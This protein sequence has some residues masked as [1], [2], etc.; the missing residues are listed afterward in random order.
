MKDTK[1]GSCL[2]GQVTF[3]LAADPIAV[4]LCHCKQCQ[5]QTSSAFSLV[6]IVPAGALQMHGTLATFQTRSASGAPVDR[7]FCAACGSP[8]RTDSAATRAQ[9]VTVLKAGLF[10]DTT[11]LK[12]SMQIFCDSAQHWVPQMPQLARFAEMPPG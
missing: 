12:P 2:C 1:S 10:D 6:A 3:S 8:V 7:S 11:W 5:K 9:G 4:A